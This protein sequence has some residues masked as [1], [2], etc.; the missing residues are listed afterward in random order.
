MGKLKVKIDNKLIE[1][2]QGTTILE[3][4]RKIILDIPTL[5]YM[6]LGDMGIEHKPGGCRIC[7]VEVEGRDVI[8]L[9]PAQPTV[10]TG[11]RLR[12]IV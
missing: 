12:P 9:L 7:V 4:A 3:A 6:N 11:W 2:E 8:L 5:C 1:V 10:M